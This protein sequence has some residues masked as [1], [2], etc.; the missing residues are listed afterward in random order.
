MKLWDK[1]DKSKLRL[2]LAKEN[3][4]EAREHSIASLEQYREGLKRRAKNIQKLL[5]KANNKV[6]K[7]Q[8]ILGGEH[9]KYDGQDLH[10]Q[11]LIM[12]EMA[13]DYAVA[14]LRQLNRCIEITEIAVCDAIAAAVIADQ[15]TID[16][17]SYD[18]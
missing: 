14:R 7:K 4:L 6:K 1:L 12:A 5:V 17:D 18:S 2:I 9:Y 16:T 10:N 11:A 8:N 3:T 13:E 15:W